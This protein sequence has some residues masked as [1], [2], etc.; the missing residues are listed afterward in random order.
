M[1]VYPVNNQYVRF[2]AEVGIDD[3]SQGGSVF[4]QALNVMPK[5]ITDQLSAQYPVQIGHLT[6]VMNDL[7]NWLITPDASVEKQ[8]VETAI[9]RLSDQSYYT[10]VAQQIANEKDLNTQIRKYLEL[11]EE[12]QTV[13]ALQNE[14]QWLNVDAIKLAFA[15]MAKQKGYDAPKFEPMLQEI[16]T[17]NK[18]GFAGIY[19][20]DKQAMANAEKA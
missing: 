18:Q 4:F 6:S 9:D 20:G 19:K 10:S 16:I 8:A 15:D 13:Y 3:S 1:L 11:L 7:D 5:N 12:V 2:E 14:L 17:L